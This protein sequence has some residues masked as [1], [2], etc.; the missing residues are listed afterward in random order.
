[1]YFFDCILIAIWLW[2]QLA[3][4]YIIK[5]PFTQHAKAG[6]LTLCDQNRVPH[7]FLFENLIDR[8]V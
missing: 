6:N 4:K 1:M 5:L 3:S 2:H 7:F 8:L